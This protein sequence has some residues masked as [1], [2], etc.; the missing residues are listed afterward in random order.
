MSPSS[1][2]LPGLEV[3]VDLWR[4]QWGIPHLRAKGAGDAFF[5]LGYVHATDRL[6]QMDALRRRATGRYAEWLGPAALPADMLARRMGMAECSQ[7]DASAANA[8]TRA[9]LESYAAGV[10]AR[11]TTAELP[12]EYALLDA[13]FEPWEPWHS[14]AAFRQGSL[15][16]NPAYPK[17]WRAIALPVVGETA[18]AQLRM[19]DGGDELVCLPSGVSARRTELNLETL[20]T[21][22]SE[23]LAQASLDATGGGSN[24]WAVHGSRTAS[25]RPLVAGD[26]HRLLDMPNLYLQC[27]VACD[28][29][30]VIG[31]T[32]PGV[33]GFPHFA[34]N[35]DVAWC[36]TVAFVDT[37]DI[38][39]ERFKDDGH[40]YLL[41]TETDGSAPHW[42]GTQRRVETIRVR[43]RAA[44]E[45]EVL[46]TARGPVV[47]GDARSGSALVL[48]HTPDA[49]TDRSFDCMRPML[50]ANSV[51]ALYEACRGWGV[52]DHNL[53]AGDTTGHIGHLVRAKIPRRSAANGWLPM[54]GW[55]DAHAWKGFVPWERM[56]RQ[57]DPDAG[58]IVTANNRIVAQQ[59]D[60]LTTDA[61]PPH[62]ARRIW[63]RLQ[64]MDAATVDDMADVH[65]DLLSIPAVEIC[66]RLAKVPLTDNGAAAL[67]DRL[68]AWDHHMRADS[69]DANAYVSLRLTLAG[70]VKRVSG[71]G[72][73][74]PAEQR[75][76]PPGLSIDYE[77]NW[78][79][80]RLLRSGDTSLIGDAT[81]DDLLAEALTVVAREPLMP[82][83][84]RHHL[85]LR[86]PLSTVFPDEAWLAT[87]DHGPVGGDNET[88]FTTGHVPRVG[89]HPAYA[90][91]ARYVFDIGNW[92]ACRWIVFHGSA[93]NPQDAHY[94]DQ[95]AMWC[96][97]E[98]I[99]M[100][101][102]WAV[103]AQHAT[104]KA[105]L[106]PRS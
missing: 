61:H 23:L 95:S 20:Q 91:I 76:I 46:R 73:L 47:A 83:G 36:V 82:W 62:R 41:R 104:S 84:D 34:H 49:E 38:Y 18:M 9:M 81:W 54:P 17:L 45:C 92:E 43:G 5:A 3:P 58:M 14:I 70:I 66:A 100:H 59:D 50:R 8:E 60:Y 94:D 96:R 16:L 6:W 35:A 48:R 27:H 93:G 67:R 69:V 99:P 10:N 7:R 78:A 85:L 30:D 65:R 86:H 22:M 31:L 90:S 29:F 4:D 103:V 68:V 39:L 21:A 80:P 26:P 77:L 52:I 64:A 98:L 51:D 2:S 88:V 32:T 57:I 87:R 53:V 71:L 24:N 25:G 74:D 75:T 63:E 12:P 79:M 19:D 1:I 106:T 44:V 102:D 33:P 28:E 40:N 15:L 56:P 11:A 89:T 55:L 97:G 42:I 37:T 72:V 13:T 101:Y 105:T